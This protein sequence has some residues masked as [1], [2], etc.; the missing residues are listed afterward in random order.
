MILG[1]KS[2]EHKIVFAG[3]V[4][5]TWGPSPHLWHNSLAYVKDPLSP[6]FPP[7]PNIMCSSWTFLSGRF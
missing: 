5:E 6:P 2:K 7:L 4:S 1:A 3:N